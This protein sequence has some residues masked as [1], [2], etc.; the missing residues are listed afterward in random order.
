MSSSHDLATIHT[1]TPRTTKWCVVEGILKQDSEMAW[2]RVRLKGGCPVVPNRF[3]R[4]IKFNLTPSYM[5]VPSEYQDN[6]ICGA[7]VRRNEHVQKTNNIET[8]IGTN[9]QNLYGQGA[10]FLF[11]IK[12]L[13]C[14]IE[15]L[16]G[17]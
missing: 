12:L 7:C 2:R 10:C 5:Q 8:S 11:V 14:I 4:Y 13:S 17:I 1:S 15:D 3:G 6:F 9:L 16:K